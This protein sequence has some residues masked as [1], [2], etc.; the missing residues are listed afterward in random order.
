MCRFL[1]HVQQRLVRDFVTVFHSRNKERFRTIFFVG[2]LITVAI[3]IVGCRTPCSEESFA[4]PFDPKEVAQLSHDAFKVAYHVK[5]LAAQD[6]R[7]STEHPRRVGREDRPGF[8]SR[9][10]WEVVRYLDR[11]SWQIAW[12]PRRI[13]DHPANAR[14]S[15]KNSFENAARYAEVIRAD[16][17]AA[18]FQPATAG[19]I[20]DL[21][22]MFDHYIVVL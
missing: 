1:L 20:E 10:D 18:S 4:R 6:I 21:L 7:F 12:V 22:Q 2:F 3:M 17:R 13:Q 8:G 15:S 11:F 5:F 9:L 19:Q 16:F 14:C